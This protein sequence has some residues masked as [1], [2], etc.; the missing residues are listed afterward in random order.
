MLAQTED[1][2]AGRGTTKDGWF[3]LQ[4]P[5]IP[6]RS[7]QAGGSFRHL[8]A[9]RTQKKNSPAHICI[10]YC[11]PFSPAERHTRATQRKTA[12]FKIL[13]GEM[14]HAQK[15]AHIAVVCAQ[16]QTTT[17]NNDCGRFSSPQHT[18]KH[19]SG[20]P[21]T[22][23]R[24]DGH[25]SARQPVR[26]QSTATSEHPQGTCACTILC[27]SFCSY[28]LLIFLFFFFSLTLAPH[29]DDIA[30]GCVSAVAE[31]LSHQLLPPPPAAGAL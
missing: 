7:P 3:A 4:S 12:A 18:K 6:D 20:V 15:T 23:H 26:C 21:G 5:E 29:P 2:G 25:Q 14:E 31:C 8:Y 9:V 1:R 24:R 17:S 30:A 19:L 11:F 28:A 10:H 22:Q 16:K 13:A 27:H